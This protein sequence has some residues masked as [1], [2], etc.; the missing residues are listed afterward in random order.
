MIKTVVSVDMIGYSSLARMPEQNLDVRAV[1]QL[2][3]QIRSFIDAGLRA[4][5]RTCERNP[6]ATNGRWSH[7]RVRYHGGGAPFRQIVS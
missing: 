2:N 1:T 7:P 5:S 3:R 6:I 4:I